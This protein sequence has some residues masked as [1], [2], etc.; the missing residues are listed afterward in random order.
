MI[1]DFIHLELSKQEQVADVKSV[2]GKIEVIK[3]SN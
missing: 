1:I 2:D 3:Y